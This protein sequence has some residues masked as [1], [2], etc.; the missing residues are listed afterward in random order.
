MAKVVSNKSRDSP[1]RTLLIDRICGVLAEKKP[2]KLL[3]EK[4][5]GWDTQVILGSNLGILEINQY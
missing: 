4:Y 3:R 1:Q 5:N 2:S